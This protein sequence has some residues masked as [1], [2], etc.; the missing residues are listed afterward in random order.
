[1]SLTYVLSK[2]RA[3]RVLGTQQVLFL[4][5]V[6]DLNTQVPTGTNAQYRAD[7]LSTATPLAYLFSITCSQLADCWIIRFYG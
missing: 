1:M 5:A 6:K 4:Q 3:A 2:R 7:H